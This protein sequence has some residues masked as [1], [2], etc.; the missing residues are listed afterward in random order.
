MRTKILYLEK[1][2]GISILLVLLFHLEIPGFNFGYYG[3]DVFFVISGFLMASLYGDIA[4]R[5]EIA[6]Y[7]LRRCARILPAYY[8]V[9]GVSSLVGILLLLPHELEML[10][11]QSLWSAFLLPNFGFWQDAAYFDYTLFRPLLNLWSLGVELQFYLL[12]PLLLFVA[13]Y[14]PRLLLT[15]AVLSYL[16]YGLFNSIDPRNA[17]FLLPGRIWEFMVG[18]F[19]CK[20]AIDETERNTVVGNLCLLALLLGVPALSVIGFDN[21][22]ISTSILLLLVFYVVR[23]GF[24][25]GADT[26]LLSRSLLNLGRYSYSVYLVHFPVIAFFNYAPFEGTNLATDSMLDL[27]FCV[28]LISLLSVLLHHA[29]EIRTKKFLRPS[30]LI[31][32]S[33]AS[34]VAIVGLSVIGPSLNRAAHSLEEIN[35]SNALLDRDNSR[36]ERRQGASALV[37]GDCAAIDL[38]SDSSRNYLLHG[39]SHADGIKL[40][41]SEVLQTRGHTLRITNNY[42]AVNSVNDNS[43]VLAEAERQNVDVIILHSL[44][45]EDSGAAL[46]GF[47]LAAAQKGMLVAFIGPVPSYEYDVPKKLANDI[48]AGILQLPAGIEL[49]T[50]LERN[51]LL[52]DRLN[53]LSARY[54]SFNWYESANFLCDEYCS[55]ANEEWIPYYFDSNHLTVTGARLLAPIFEQIGSL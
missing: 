45:Q 41:L 5:P 16:E 4:T 14:S 22:F 24:T 18:Y 42:A 2:R 40:A 36:C 46:E 23:H 8:L 35:I 47:I 49:Q 20:Y 39:D 55:I 13:R 50:H 37:S 6:N 28:F 3:V 21:N 38:G 31:A 33:I 12:F 26:G 27:A 52:F 11:K 1:L 34:T 53:E 44:P 48:G 25:T 9:I 10:M 19:A 30:I 32:V 7:L 17:F 15:I 54:D 43:L 51:K 29:V